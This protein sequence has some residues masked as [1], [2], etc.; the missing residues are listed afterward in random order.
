MARRPKR[1]VSA[2]H[3]PIAPVVE[4]FCPG[5][6]FIRL[7]SPN[8]VLSGDLPRAAQLRLV[9]N[10]PALAAI[11]EEERK[12][13]LA[14]AANTY[15]RGAYH[16]F[17]YWDLR[18]ELDSRRAKMPGELLWDHLV[19]FVHFE[20]QAFLGAS[21]TLI[22]E[23][24]YVIA[25]CHGEPESS[26]RNKWVTSDLITKP[27]EPK[28]E[29]DEVKLLRSEALWFDLINSYRNT[30]F[31]HG[32]RHGA[33]HYSIGDQHPAA[34]LAAAN[35]LLVPDQ[36]SLKGRRKPHDWTWND[37]T[38]IDDLARSVRDGTER[39]LEQLLDNI[40]ATP[41]PLPGTIPIEERPNLLVGIV[42]PVLL[43]TPQEALL[44]L[45]ST[46]EHAEKLP[47]LCSKPELE[48][49]NVPATSVFSREPSIAFAFD[50]IKAQISSESV[51]TIRILDRKSV[52]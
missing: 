41:M 35:G 46:R 21:R 30:F 22:D 6:V 15:T 4:G 36:A 47:P 1:H 9:R 12:A 2:R 7:P 40:W 11:P 20:M 19:Q 49:V 13:I 29:V 37:R 17:R 27:I 51:G 42:R 8:G 33:G 43:A 38:T 24:V 26:A 18:R 14:S 16:E 48:L 50:H 23:L 31:H 25:R 34:Q 32:W 39:V 44:V 3:E 5:A 52:V 45:F 28:Y 10:A